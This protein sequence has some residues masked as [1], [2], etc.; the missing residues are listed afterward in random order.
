LGRREDIPDLIKIS[1]LHAEQHHYGASPPEYSY[2]LWDTLAEA[3]H[4]VFFVAYFAGE[5]I[6]A[7]SNLAFGKVLFA[8]YLVDDGEHRRLNAPTLLHWQAMRWGQENGCRWYDFGG[9]KIYLARILLA[10]DDLPDTVEGRRTKFKLSFGGEVVLR[11]G[12]YDL[13]YVGSQKLTSRLV[14]LAMQAGP[15]LAALVGPRLAGYLQM[16]HRSVSRGAGV[17]EEEGE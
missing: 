1:H 14:P 13:A 16:H 3:G 2:R 5:P 11:A 4:F 17:E 6:A 12:A 15:M 8:Q 10:G 9:I 7:R